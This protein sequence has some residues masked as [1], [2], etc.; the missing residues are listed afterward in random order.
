MY[1]YC[2]VRTVQYSTV[3]VLLCMY[4]VYTCNVLYVQCVHVLYCTY[5]HVLFCMYSV[6]IC[7][8]LYVQ[9]VHVLFCMY[10]VYMYCTVCTVYGFIQ[11][12]TII[13]VSCMVG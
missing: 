10:S 12:V 2:T 5:V 8:V 4:S 9:C 13:E 1:I 11:C 7:T 6:Y 3:H